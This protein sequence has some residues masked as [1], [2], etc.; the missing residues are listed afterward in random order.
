MLMSRMR[1]A[2]LRPTSIS[3]SSAIAA[4]GPTNWRLAVSLLEEAKAEGIHM[5]AICYNAAISAVGHAG[6][7]QKAL[8]ILQVRPDPQPDLHPSA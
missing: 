6:E 7:W 5:D 4:C 3:Y 1:Q 2:G 8:E